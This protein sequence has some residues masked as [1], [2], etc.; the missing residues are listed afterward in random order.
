MKPVLGMGARLSKI[1][2]MSVREIVERG[3]YGAVVRLERTRYELGR[4]ARPDRLRQAL[5]PAMG[6]AGWQGRL[7][8]S[9]RQHRTRFF[10]G[11]RDR[12]AMRH[13]FETRY[14]AERKATLEQA[15]RVRSH[16]F[17]FFGRQLQ[18]ADDIDWQADPD[19]GRR[20]P[21]VYHRD[22]PVHQGDAGF[23][24]VKDVWE[25]NRQQFLID[26]GKAYFLAGDDRDL[27][28]MRGLVRSW[29]S[30]NPYATGVNWS[31]ALEPAFRVFSWLWAYYLTV[32]ALDEEFHLEWLAAFHDHGRF[33]ST[34]LEYYSSPYNHLIGEAA[35]LYMLGTCFPEFRQ[36]ERW[37]HQGRLVLEQRLGSQFYEDGGSV[38]QSTFYHHATVGFYLLALLIARAAG[39]EL[40]PAVRAAVERGIAFSTALQQPD[41]TTPRIGG[42]DDGKPI[43]M[44]H[45][46]LWDFR[47]YQAIG[48]VLFDRRDFKS[49]AG[50]FPEDALWLL[51]PDALDRFDAL[52]S[53]G[54]TAAAQAPSASG[55]VVMRSDRSPDADYVCFDCGEQ[56]AGM[57]T[58]GVPN[59]MHGHADCLSIIAWLGGRPVL[60]DSGFYSYNCGGA[61][62]AHFRETAAHSTARVDGRDQ[63]RHIGKMAWSHSYRAVLEGSAVEP[64]VFWVLGSHDGYSRGPEGIVHRRAVSLRPGAYLLIYD[65]FVGRGE[66]LFE[67]NYQFAPG[68]LDSVDDR[69]ARFDGFAEIAW[70][71]SVPWTSDIRNGGASP[72]QGW[73]ASS[74]GVKAP[75]PRLRLQARGTGPRTSLLT[76]MAAGRPDR[77]RIST[78]HAGDSSAAGLLLAVSGDEQ[79]DWIAAAG[80][81]AGGAMETDAYVAVCRVQGDELIDT[82]RIGGTFVR[83]E[84]G[85]LV[86]CAPHLPVA[87]G[88]R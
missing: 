53:G 83:S 49:A 41:G 17:E 30:G 74:L 36:S 9:R 78:V 45:L 23:G 3:R 15:A 12:A 32:E 59:A 8:A 48:A 10:D 27:A 1:R 84:I 82:T 57:R 71:G 29:I 46:P 4:L 5:Q 66:H 34:H 88:G 51:G 22:V 69:C 33:L 80:V 86:E 85:Y 24:D 50:R 13:L 63:A 38:E 65:E 64:P 43:R 6:D 54:R 37:R 56:A 31:C 75:A 19:T 40:S 44:E 52:P 87:K 70:T 68:S 61:W 73:I 72:D 67:V 39:E 81:T 42:A 20:W 62:E 55:Y 26:L 28:A 11:V 79:T 25:L 16:Q 47:P 35:A 77:R 14:G 7:M 76:V 18:Y 21:P 2:A 60:V 58:D